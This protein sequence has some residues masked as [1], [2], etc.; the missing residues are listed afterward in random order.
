MLN[1][2]NLTIIPCAVIMHSHPYEQIR[3]Y[4][5]WPQ[6]NGISQQ[7]EL[8]WAE[9]VQRFNQ[10]DYRG[11]GKGNGQAQMPGVCKIV[12]NR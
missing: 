5:H 9:Q 10:E 1:N 11:G 2:E 7:A 3:I 8:P 12:S 4:L 6:S